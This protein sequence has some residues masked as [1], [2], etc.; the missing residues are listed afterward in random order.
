[1]NILSIL[2]IVNSKKLT[3]IT[4]SP[5]VLHPPFFL[6]YAYSNHPIPPELRIVLPPHI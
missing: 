4:Y 1:M 6:K 3:L 5:E 2:Y